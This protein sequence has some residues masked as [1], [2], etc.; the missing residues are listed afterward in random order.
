MLA[1]GETLTAW[2]RGRLSTCQGSRP[3]PGGLNRGAERVT[4]SA[5]SVSNSRSR[6]PKAARRRRAFSDW[7]E[8]L[9]KYKVSLRKLLATVNCRR[10][11]EEQRSS[12]GGIP[13]HASALRWPC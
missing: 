10:N 2:R 12:L 8:D 1:T 11:M 9:L 6:E 4:S 13:I 3:C 5:E 7:Y